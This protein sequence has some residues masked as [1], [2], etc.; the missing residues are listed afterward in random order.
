MSA[1]EKRK[2]KPRKFSQAI[3]AS[4]SNFFKSIFLILLLVG[5]AVLVVGSYVMLRVVDDAPHLDVA[6]IYATNSTLIFDRNGE[7][8]DERGTERREWV[9][10]QDISP[11]MI[12]A[13]VATEDANFFNH[14]GVDW[15]RTII[16]NV[17]N[18]GTW[19]GGNDLIQGGSTITQQLIKMSHLTA[20]QEGWEGIRRKIQEIYLSMQIEQQLTKEQILAA[21]LNFAPFGGSLNGVQR[22][23]EFY[24][25]TDAAN[26]TLGEAAALAGMVQ[27][28]NT[29]RPDHNPDNTERRR[30]VVLELM[31]RHGYITDEM[32]TL[33]AADPVTDNLIYTINELDSRHKYQPFIDAVLAEV[34]DRFELNAHSGLQIYTNM[35]RNA[36]AFLYD[37]QN[38]N[39]HVSWPDANMQTGIAFIET[40][41]GRV[42]AVGRGRDG[43]EGEMNLNRATSI[44]RQPGSTAKSPFV[45]APGMEFLG[46]GTGTSFKDELWPWPDSQQILRNWNREYQGTQTMRQAL[47]MSWNVPAGKGMVQLLDTVGEA[48]MHEWLE[49][50]GL[51]RE[52]LAGGSNPNGDLFPS[53]AIGGVA[54]GWSP[55]Q[56]AAAYAAFGNGG[57]Y[58]EPFFID[59]IV[60]PDGTVI[61]GEDNRITHRAMSEETAWMTTD[62]LKSVMTE[63]TGARFANQG[64]GHMNLAGKTG[65]TNF[66]DDD[67]VRLGINPNTV[68]MR[69]SWFIGF[70][71][72]YTAAVWTGY[73]RDTDGHIINATQGISGQVFNQIMRNL[74]TG[75]QQLPRPTGVQGFT[76]ELESG[77]DGNVLLASTN[78][79]PSYRS[80]E[81]F[82]A[83]TQPTSA[84]TRFSQL[85]APQNFTGTQSG[86]NLSFNWDHVLGAT[87]LSRDALVSAIDNANQVGR[88][89]ANFSDSRIQALNI[90]EAQG[91][92]MLRQL[93]TIGATVYTVFGRTTDGSALN[94]GT[95]IENSLN[96]TVSLG[97]LAR[98]TEFYVVARFENWSGL[99][100]PPSNTF[101][102]TIDPSLLQVSIPNMRGWTTE[103]AT[104]WADEN[105]VYLNF[106]QEAS[107]EIEENLI[108]STNPVNQVPIGG[109]IQVIVSTGPQDNWNIPEE[110][111]SLPTPEPDLEEES[112]EI[113][114]QTVTEDV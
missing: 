57:I 42:R 1:N 81:W 92:M 71:G 33:A 80:T 70:S 58:N 4:F 54:Q 77:T 86:T 47:N 109:T 104:N 89:A 85:D 14:N 97:E 34:R 13:I 52:G 112:N 111:E 60:M 17:Q 105:A 73:D 106:V 82:R 93:D 41:T 102:L 51:D 9:D 7:L 69:D 90:T 87:S 74:N 22:A 108:V 16:A 5:I 39:D 95:T 27:A 114:D 20:E 12:D 76:I 67:Y 65:T 18:L 56:M 2:K 24:F 8:I 35:D 101:Q 32:A 59:R 31:V 3:S 100:S 28:P 21:Y 11:V 50:L 61:Y 15:R 63:G 83:G 72:Q 29:W 98:I 103:Q 96:T 40:M 43:A 46:W 110:P 49:Q 79:P 37:L 6:S 19:F 91:R 44:R 48:Q 113:P 26:L 107:N 53:A 75:N 25:D 30:D 36:Q 38:T 94:I 64:I 66:S 84:S 62:T 45:Y 55:L 23:A 68:A 78:T 99:D 88:T 10:F